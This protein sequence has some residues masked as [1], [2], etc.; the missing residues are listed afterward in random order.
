MTT[1]PTLREA[2]AARMAEWD[3]QAKQEPSL[4]YCG[5][6]LAGEAGEAMEAALDVIEF[7]AVI[8]RASN[9]I[10][11][12][13]RE[14]LGMPG[15]RASVDDLADELADAMICIRRLEV[16]LGLGLDAAVVR[17]FNSKSEELGL[18]TRVAG[19]TR[20]EKKVTCRG[21][22]ALGSGCGHCERCEQERSQMF[23]PRARVYVYKLPGKL[24]TGYCFG[25]GHDIPFRN[26]DWFD[27]PV[28]EGREELIGF[29]KNKQYF[30]KTARFLVLSD[31]SQLT[32]TIEPEAPNAR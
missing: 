21:S 5:N 23:T 22:L 6:E 20:T 24:T 26:V 3:G 25:G 8:G 4:S 28:A 19:G 30:D 27:A 29:I 31:H 7:G 15:S 2:V 10:K 11:K 13:D 17:K 32:F 1:Y 16:R 14:M 9:I 18:K 12:I